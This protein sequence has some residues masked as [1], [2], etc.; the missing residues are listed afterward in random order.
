MNQVNLPP[1]LKAIL[2]EDEVIVD[3]RQKASV[4]KENLKPSVAASDEF[5]LWIDVF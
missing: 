4:S 3:V 1:S 5:L 2:T